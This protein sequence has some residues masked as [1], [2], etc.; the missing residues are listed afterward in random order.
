M[1]HPGPSLLWGS[2]F[3]GLTTQQHASV[4]QG[5]ICLTTQQHASVSQGRI[6]LTT[7]QHASVSQGRIC[8]TTQ[9]HE[10]VSQGR[11]CLTTQQH[12][13][14]SRG[15]IYSD[16]CMCRHTEAQVADQ[17][18][19]IT[20][21]QCT[22]TGPT[23]LC[24]DPITPGSWQENNNNTNGIQ[25]RYSRFFTI[26]SERRE[27]SPIRTLKWPGRNRVQIT[28]NTSSAYH[29]QVSCYVPLGTKGQLS[30]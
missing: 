22:D 23:I 13:S 1:S 15:R 29:V 21:S 2:A 16:N 11:I 3:G 7:Q 5:R 25:S 12:A 26:F 30:Y 14:V 18:F 19:C 24:T 27:L 20:Q 10:S 8:L 6:C 28:C 9:Q 17:T 4:S